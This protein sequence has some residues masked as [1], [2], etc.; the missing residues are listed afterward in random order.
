MR[1]LSN[2]LVRL[3]SILSD[4]EFHDG[5]SIGAELGVTR[6]AVWKYIKKLEEYGIKV[7]S[8]KNK[9]YSLYEPLLLLDKDLITKEIDNPNIEIEVLETID[10]TNSYLKNK[11]NNKNRQICLSENQTSGRGRMGRE[12]HS[13]FGQ[14]LYMS[15]SYPF[16]KDI[17]EIAGLSL[18]ISMAMLAALREINIS[19]PI[20]LKWPNDGMY[21]GQKIMGNLVEVQAEAHGELLAII[22]MGINVN[23]LDA[24]NISQDWSSIRKISGKYID[25]NKLCIA[26][27]HNLNLYI[28]KFSKYGLQDFIVEWQG[29]DSLY[30]KQISLNDGEFSGISKG[31]NEQG[32]LLLELSNGEIKTFSSGDAS[33]VKK[34]LL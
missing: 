30:G 4:L 34:G 18:V 8:V 11:L 9:G 29:L 21:E 26:L 3:S 24:D 23:I 28:E 6:T 16:K 25:R 22:G 19:I 12:W 7:K 32:K 5:D 14:N 17:S 20:Q 33:I 10:S 27:I 1:I 15:Y 13:P 31:I 2:N